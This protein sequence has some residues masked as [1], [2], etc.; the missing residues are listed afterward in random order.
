[1]VDIDAEQI[2]PDH[3]KHGSVEC[4]EAI[5]ASMTEE[6]F[7]GYLKG[8]VMKYL[9]RLGRKGDKDHE[10]AQW[11]MRRLVNVLNEQK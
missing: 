5:Q 6:E 8:N 2:N 3:Y 9:W 4:I 1:M 11:Y 7:V 10:K